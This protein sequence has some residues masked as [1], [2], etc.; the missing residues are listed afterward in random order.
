MAKP[1]A[2]ETIAA[3]LTVPERVLLFRHQLGEGCGAGSRQSRRYRLSG[4]TSAMYDT[5]LV[6]AYFAV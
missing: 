5:G 3:E 4:V 6:G 1:P 2:T